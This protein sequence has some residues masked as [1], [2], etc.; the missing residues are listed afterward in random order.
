MW[1]LTYSHNLEYQRELIKLFNMQSRCTTPSYIYLYLPPKKI[2][3][4]NANSGPL[5]HPDTKNKRK[6]EKKRIKK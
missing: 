6:K 2:I 5:S 1:D 3:K 4:N